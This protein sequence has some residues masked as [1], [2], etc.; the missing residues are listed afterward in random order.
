MSSMLKSE[1]SFKRLE[2][3]DVLKGIGIILVAIGHI[4]SNTVIYNWLY[5]F[6]MPLFFFAAGWLYK[7]SE[8]LYNIKRRVQTIVLPY[9]LFGLLILV[10]WQLVERKFR[11]SSM[12]FIDAFI[13]LLRGQYNYLDFNVHLWFLPAFFVTVVFYNILSKLGGNKIAYLISTLMSIVYILFPLSYLPWG[14]DRMFMYIGFY[15]IGNVLANLK[16][17]QFIQK[18]H[19]AVKASAAILFLGINFSLAYFNLTK[20]IMW[21]ITAMFGVI[22][23]VIISLIINKNAVLQYL[24][25]ISLVVLCIHGPVYRIIVK[26]M[27]IPLHMTTDALRSNFFL[28]M[29]VVAVTLIICSI[30]YEIILRIMPVM[31]GKKRKSLISKAEK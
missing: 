11:D 13:G 19:I 1:E 27:S 12:S 16:A 4:Y 7:K 9:F 6:H 31:I 2:W 22:A 24:G 29:I 23:C 8:I 5:S 28:A 14:I 17:D 26:A 3:L 10:Y 18:K 25:R 20:G 21:Y 30:A 15:A